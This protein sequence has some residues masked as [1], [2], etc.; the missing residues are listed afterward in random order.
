MP[1][2]TFPRIGDVGP[3]G[4]KRCPTDLTDYCRHHSFAT[5]PS[6]L[7]S[8]SCPHTVMS[9]LHDTNDLRLWATL[10][11]AVDTPLVFETLG[12]A[13]L[14]PGLPLIPSHLPVLHDFQPFCYVN[15]RQLFFLQH[16]RSSTFP[17]VSQLERGPLSGRGLA[18]RGTRRDM[19]SLRGLYAQNL[20][21]KLS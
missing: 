6:N 21:I 12:Q 16:V 19:G 1:A 18:A 20:P 7:P 3:A 10:S 15:L 11:A 2:V 5:T 4:V 14:H 17:H 9:M 8:L 13:T